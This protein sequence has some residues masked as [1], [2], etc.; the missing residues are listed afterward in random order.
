MEKTAAALIVAAGR[1]TRLADPG[2][3]QPKQYRLVAG[4][5]VLSHTLA[6][7]ANHPR[8]SKIITV[9]HPD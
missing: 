8:V 5:P 3:A 9:I 4:R 1:G 7:L 6:A 2:A